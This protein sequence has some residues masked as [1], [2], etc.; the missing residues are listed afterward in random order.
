M[1]FCSILIGGDKSPDI[2]NIYHEKN[3]V[4]ENFLLKIWEYFAISVSF[5]PIIKILQ[6]YYN[7][8]V[9]NHAAK[10]FSLLFPTT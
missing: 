6:S 7:Y 2:R 1:P 3:A 8:Y 10:S 5:N 9:L 4:V